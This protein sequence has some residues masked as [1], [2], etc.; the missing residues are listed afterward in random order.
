[1]PGPAAQLHKGK[2][3]TVDIH[4]QL[5]RRHDA[6]LAWSGDS[7]H[8]RRRSAGCPAGETR[9]AMPPERRDLRWIHPHKH[10]KTGPCGDGLAGLVLIE[11]DVRFANCACRNSGASTMCR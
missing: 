9:T 8:R 10:G 3:V 1:M 2:S 5:G 4:N 11:D 6:S 7:G